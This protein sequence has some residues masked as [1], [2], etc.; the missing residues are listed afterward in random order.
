MNAR[1]YR[2]C[3]QV[4]ITN[5][6]YYLSILGLKY[7]IGLIFAKRC[8]AFFSFVDA[9]NDVEPNFTEGV[10]NFVMKWTLIRREVRT[11]CRFRWHRD[12]CRIK[13]W[14]DSTRG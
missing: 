7:A 6:F 13:P 9:E 11:S 14:I 5:D 8:K 10:R 3:T 4:H 1:M 2:V 12:S